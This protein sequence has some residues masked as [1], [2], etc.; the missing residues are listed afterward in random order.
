[1]PIGPITGTIAFDGQV[2]SGNCSLGT[3]I[4]WEPMKLSTFN[5]QL[6]L[7]N[8]GQDAKCIQKNVADRVIILNPR[9]Y[10]FHPFLAP[11]WTDLRLGFFL[12]LCGNADPVEDDDTIT[13]IAETIPNPSVL[14]SW[15]RYW[16][17]V[18]DSV[19]GKTF[20]GFTNTAAQ[21][22]DRQG[23]QHAYRQRRRHGHRAQLSGARAI[24]KIASCY[25]AAIFDNDTNRTP[26][27]TDLQQHF[28]QDA[29]TVAAGY[30]VLLGLQLTRD[31]TTSKNITMNIKST[32]K[33]AD[34]LYSNTPTK[35]LLHS[36]LD[37]WPASKQLGPVLVSNVPDTFF[38]YWPWHNST[39]ANP[40]PGVLTGG[41]SKRNQKVESGKLKS[42]KRK[43]EKTQEVTWQKET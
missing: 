28:P 25:S 40:Y 14:Q 5:F 36:S 21:L 8:M 3:A 33:S 34:M 17:G 23:R 4:V 39:I 20:A 37:P 18:V 16:L 32:T 9:A 2:N 27:V 19:T 26:S 15:D 24:Q 35:E 29:G 41:M 22:P 13:G 43:R 12:S 11:D 10:Y 38:F 30:A 1:M 6:Q 31:N 7:L 42:R